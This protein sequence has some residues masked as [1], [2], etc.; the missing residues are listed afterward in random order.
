MFA[1]IF[2]GAEKLLRQ[3]RHKR[4]YKF[5][6]HMW[7]KTQARATKTWSNKVKN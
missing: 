6:L 4:I 5:A 1:R 2:N 3:P 7:A